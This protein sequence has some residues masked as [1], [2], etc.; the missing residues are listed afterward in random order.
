M[1]FLAYIIPFKINENEFQILPK[2]I[3]WG[4]VGIFFLYGAKLN[5]KQIFSDLKNWK[6][7]FLIQSTTFLIFPAIILIF[8][9]LF[10]DGQYQQLWLAT[11]FLAALPSTV[12]SSVVMV[13][14]G[15]GNIGSA[16][17]N[18]SISGIIGL[19]MT[20]IWMGIFLKS[21]QTLE[22]LPLVQQLFF[23]ILLPVILGLFFNKHLKAFLIKQ[24]SSVAWFDKI[25]IFLIVYKSFSAAFLD[26]VFGQVPLWTMAL[27]AIFILAL[28]FFIYYLIAWGAKKLALNREDQIT[29][30]YCASKKSLV[31]GSVFVTLL[32]QDLGT[33]SLFLLP[34]MIYHSAQLFYTS[35]TA[36]KYA[37]EKR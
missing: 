25:I 13:S 29:A 32:I 3:Y 19:F 4:I 7:H 10:R 27:L 5:L 14:I 28:F 15:K 6:L 11:F 31:H 16:I 8:Y 20:P 9:P 33:Q 22:I 35:Y 30:I 2:I 1:I 36:R 21:S 24:K 23:Q 18:A 26:N 12:S 37:L 34:I 17:F